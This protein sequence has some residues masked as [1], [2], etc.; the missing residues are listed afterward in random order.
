MIKGYYDNPKSVKLW[1][2]MI[3]INACIYGLL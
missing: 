3:A 1:A 2:A